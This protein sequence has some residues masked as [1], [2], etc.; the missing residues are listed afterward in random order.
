MYNERCSEEELRDA[1][2]MIYPHREHHSKK[3]NLWH[4]EVRET[5]WNMRRHV[6]IKMSNKQAEDAHSH[7]CVEKII[8]LHFENDPLTFHAENFRKETAITPEK[9]RILDIE[10]EKLQARGYPL[11]KPEL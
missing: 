5:R 2:D 6:Q 8:P 11:D 1:M 9:Q 7:P 4:K 3:G 10:N